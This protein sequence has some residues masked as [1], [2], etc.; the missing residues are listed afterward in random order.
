MGFIYQL[1]RVSLQYISLIKI[2]FTKCMMPFV[3]KIII[4][5]L[6]SKTNKNCVSA[7]NEPS[8]YR[9]SENS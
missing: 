5:L 6:V 9:S 4:K 8:L 3:T 7:T 1:T 2:S